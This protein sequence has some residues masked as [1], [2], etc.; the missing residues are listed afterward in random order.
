MDFAMS[1]LADG[2]WVHVYPEGRVN[3]RGDVTPLLPLRWGVGR[4]VAEVPP[5]APVPVVVP[6]YHLGMDGVLPNVKPYVPRLL[7]RQRVTVCVGRPVDVE[8]VLR[9]TEGQSKEERRKAVT[10]A[11]DKALRELRKEAE[12]HHAKHTFTGRDESTL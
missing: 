4:M 1:R 2:Q 9:D 8:R 5:D 7:S 12:I 3:E 6:I 10:E 11:V